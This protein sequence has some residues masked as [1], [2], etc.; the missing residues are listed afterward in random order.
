MNK[1]IFWKSLFLITL[2]SFSSSITADQSLI[3]KGDLRLR[4]QNDWQSNDNRLRERFNFRF[5]AKKELSKQ[6]DINFG[7]A[8]GDT[9]SRS[10]NQT[11][12]NSFETVDIRLD[13][14]YLKHN[15]SNSIEFTL[16]KMKNPVWTPS[17]LLW[18][19]DINP[20]G[21]H[22]NYAT[23]GYKNLNINTALFIIDENNNSTDKDPVLAVVQPQY[24]WDLNRQTTIKNALSIY[25]TK[26]VKGAAFGSQS[27]GTNTGA[28]TGLNDEFY[29]ITLSSQVSL[30]NMYG[31]ELIQPFGELV[32][33]TNCDSNNR[34]GIIGIKL[35][36]KK[37]NSRSAWQT[38]VSYRY[39]E[40]DA[41]LDILPDSDAYG[42]ATDRKGFEIILDYGLSKYS[43]LTLDYYAMNKI[44][45]T[46]S[47][48][49]LV[50][51]DL[52]IKF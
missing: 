30:A 13:Y 29:P 19:S 41:W 12:D 49:Y 50:Q 39:L 28:T 27:A 14:A 22:L 4:L 25:L 8:T 44:S 15:Y 21:I 40:S 45:N 11:Y 37:V 17:D 38:K 35:G 20:N 6:T 24:T 32:L 33:N 46:V 48:D 52:N 47:T 26:D 9:D 3:F 2:V 31:L 23:Q 18:D 42:G 36:N 1:H 10:T 7:L 43:K 16:G 34:G 51:L 5:G